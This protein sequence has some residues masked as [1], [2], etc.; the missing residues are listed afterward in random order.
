M[1]NRNQRAPF[2]VQQVG[3]AALNLLRRIVR[4]LAPH[5]GRRPAALPEAAQVCHLEHRPAG[6]SRAVRLEQTRVVGLE[7]TEHA[8]RSEDSLIAIRHR[9]RARPQLATWAP[10]ATHRFGGALAGERHKCVDQGSRWPMRP[11]S[12]SAARA[13]AMPPQLVAT[14]VTSVSSSYRSRLA[15]SRPK[16]SMLMPGWLRCARSA[17]PVKL[18]VYT[19][20]PVSRRALA[21]LRQHQPPKYM[22][23]TRTMG[24]TAP[25]VPRFGLTVCCGATAWVV[26]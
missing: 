24:F 21:T 25:R 19:R 14:R 11:G 6:K 2:G 20:W 8:L 7:L 1:A 13:T 18:G 15:M 10:T 22:P 4:A 5:H 16:V 23:W 17:Q 9:S 12:S 3:R 26:S